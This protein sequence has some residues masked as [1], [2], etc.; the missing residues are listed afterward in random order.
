MSIAEL[1]FNERARILMYRTGGRARGKKDSADS[2]V[3]GPNSALTQFLKEQGINAESIRQKW[4]KSRE[5]EGQG[6][7]D[8][9]KKEEDEEEENLVLSEIT[10]NNAG[11]R[12][13]AFSSSDDD[14]ASD[15]V[16]L[17]ATSD[18]GGN[19]YDDDTESEDAIDPPVRIGGD[20]RLKRFAVAAEDS[21]EEEYD[22]GQSSR[23]VS[24]TPAPEITQEQ[25]E[26]KLKKSKQ[27]LQQRRRKKRKAADLLDRKTRRISTLQD[28]CIS[29]ISAN[30]LRL[31]QS[32][33][34]KDDSISSQIRNTLGG[35]STQNMNKLARTLSKN[36]ALNDHTLQLFLRT[37]LNT[38]TFHDC[39]KVSYEGYKLLAIFAPHLSEL[40]LQMCGQL[41]NEALMYIEEKLPKLTSLDVDGPFLIN[42]DTWDQFFRKMK[43]RLTSFHISNTHRFT[44]NSLRSLLENCGDSLKSL[45]LA[46]LDDLSDYSMISKYLSNSSFERLAIEYPSREDYVTDDIVVETL[47]KVGST[48]KHLSLNGCSELTDASFINAQPFL[49]NKEAGVCL[50][51]SLQLEELDQLTTD[52]LVYFISQTPMPLLKFC[53]FKRCFQ[54]E[55]PALT[56]LFLNDA[57]RSLVTLVLNSLKEV[58]GDCFEIMAC[59]NLTR[60]DM[61][62]MPCAKDELVKKLGEQNPKLEIL[63][64]FGD[65]LISA[66]AQIRA[67]LTVI[68]RQSDTL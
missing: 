52:G 42:E 49:I 30:I 5:K 29:Q 36:R 20:S 22:E 67:G 68:G 18:A 56:E 43:G 35:I 58:R 64:V 47:S 55:D 2:G 32:T 39:S 14:I 23:T 57:A 26:S 8:G 40:S 45:K 38:L 51:Q 62:F 12:R 7:E 10:R 44:N 11:K 34:S 19:E 37:N 21:D 46:R 24:V 54:L 59:P 65:N 6:E 66:K 1:N 61:G 9:P 25:L 63:E 41:N 50:L 16:A 31:Q 33:D 4:L 60:L 27:L 13:Q 53:N 15:D 48:I 17:D 28:I 3:R